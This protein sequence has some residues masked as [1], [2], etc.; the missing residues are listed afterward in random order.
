MLMKTKSQMFKTY[1]V[2][3]NEYP[4]VLLLGNGIC[5]CYG[6]VPW[7]TLLKSIAARD[8]SEDEKETMKS[9]PNPLQAVVYSQD[10][11]DS[12]LDNILDRFMPD[13]TAGLKDSEKRSLLF[14][15]YIDRQF[16]TILTTNYSYEIEQA[17]D[18]DF[19]IKRGRPNKYRQRS[20]VGTSKEHQ[21]GI[22]RFNRVENGKGSQDIW[23][24]H[25]EAALKNSVVLG[26][27]YYGELL[28]VIENYCKRTIAYYGQCITKKLPFHLKSWID[29][30]LL[31]DV[32]IIGFSMDFSEMD[33]WWLI[34]CKKRH[35][36]DCGKVYLYEPL[37]DN[38]PQL[39]LL[40]EAYGVVI[41]SDGKYDFDYAAY[42]RKVADNLSI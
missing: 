19:F 4:K 30:F 12:F 2:A 18:P 9:I 6:S 27:Y 22:F 8:F 31:G 7:N 10:Q 21:F 36:P 17:I 25:G 16:D 32:F 34:N 23:H 40:A 38:K 35:F 14:R 28:S 33:I 13:M 5:R 1:K 37:I 20:E 24:I 3:E 42:Y 39:R 41:C 26:H 29:Y 15:S 11:I